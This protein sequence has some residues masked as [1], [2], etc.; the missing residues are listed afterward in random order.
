MRADGGVDAHDPEPAE[1][2]LAVVAI[3][4]GVDAGADEV[5]F[6]GSRQAATAADVSLRLLN[7]RFL[8]LVRAPPFVV[9]IAKPLCLCGSQALPSS[10]KRLWKPVPLVMTPK[11]RHT[12][13]CSAVAAGLSGRGC[14]N[15]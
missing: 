15:S 14:N 3:A 2:A 12:R 1:I 4:V 6:G 8:A 7:S 11:R 13:P 9:L 10:G 5:F